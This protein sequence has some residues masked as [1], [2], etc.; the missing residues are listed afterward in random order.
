[1]KPRLERGHYDRLSIIRWLEDG[2][3]D[4]RALIVL[5]VI[6]PHNQCAI[7][8]VQLEDGIGQNVAQA[9]RCE[10]GSHPSQHHG[11]GSIP[12]DDEATNMTSSPV[13][14]QAGGICGRCDSGSG[15]RVGVAGVGGWASESLLVSV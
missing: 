2:T 5:P 1:M 6:V 15:A 10:R 11:L 14:P 8:A 7:G 3:F 12:R 4:Q 13:S 9:H